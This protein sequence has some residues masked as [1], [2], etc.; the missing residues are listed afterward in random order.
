M[1]FLKKESGK[2]KV[3]L[4]DKDRTLKGMLEFLSTNAQK[5]ELS[6]DISF[7]PDKRFDTHNFAIFLNDC[8]GQIGTE[9]GGDYFELDDEIRKK[10]NAH[11]ISNPSSTWVEIKSK[12]L[13]LTIRVSLERRPRGLDKV[14]GY[15]PAVECLHL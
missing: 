12:F 11:I 10:I 4:F 7:D 2:K 13:M 14:S 1:A 5:Y 3:T 6:I 9:A 15:H 8:R